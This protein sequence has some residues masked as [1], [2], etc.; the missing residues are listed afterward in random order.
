MYILYNTYYICVLCVFHA[1][2]LF[3]W[4]NAWSIKRF[5]CYFSKKKKCSY[6]LDMSTHK[7]QSSASLSLPSGLSFLSSGNLCLVLPRCLRAG[8]SPPAPSPLHAEGTCWLLPFCLLGR[9]PSLCPHLTPHL[10]SSCSIA[11]P[12]FSLYRW[13]CCW[14]YLLWLPTALRLVRACGGG[15]CAAAVPKQGTS[16]LFLVCK[17]FS[18]WVGVEVFFSPL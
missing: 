10:F 11:Q 14:G 12:Q 3:N 17:D 2:I 15:G 7:S 13:V 4:W 6:F 5:K 9:I 16:F 18:S 8:H 1:Q